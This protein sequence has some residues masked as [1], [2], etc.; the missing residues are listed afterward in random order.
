MEP[1]LVRHLEMLIA[2]GSTGPSELDQLGRTHAQS[3]LLKTY[4]LEVSGLRL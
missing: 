3:A 4:A 1:R 2:A